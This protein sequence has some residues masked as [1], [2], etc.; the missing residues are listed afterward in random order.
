MSKPTTVPHRVEIRLSDADRER[1]SVL[2]DYY[3]TDVQAIRV[4][5]R[6]S[7]SRLA[8]TTNTEGA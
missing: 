2:R 5:V 6:E 7:V 3:G 1:L 8:S 4:A